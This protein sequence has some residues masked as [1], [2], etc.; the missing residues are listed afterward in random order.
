MLSTSFLSLA[1]VAPLVLAFDRHLAHDAL[2]QRRHLA[3][4]KRQYGAAYGAPAAPAVPAVSDMASSWSSAS[5]AASSGMMGGDSAMAHD[6][7]M[8]TGHAGASSYDTANWA[9]SE[10][11]SAS[12]AWGGGGGIA[13]DQCVQQCMV[14]SSM[15][16]PAAS[17]TDSMASAPPAAS[18]SA[19]AGGDAPPPPAGY[20]TG[21]VAGP[22]QVVVAPKKGDLR[23]VPFNIAVKP[24]ETVEFVWGAGPHTVTQSSAASIC[25]ASQAD[26]AF[27]SGMQNATFTFPVKVKD[28]KPVFYYCAV[29]MHCK[30]GMFGLINGQVSLDGNSSFGSYMKTWAA[31]NKENQQ[32]WDETVKITIDFPDFASWGDNLSTTQFED[33]ALPMAMESTLMTRQYF[34][35]NALAASTNGSS[36]SPSSPSSPTSAPGGTAA[37]TDPS[38]SSDA[39]VS[40]ARALGA[41]VSTVAVIVGALGVGVFLEVV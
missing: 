17:A 41:A 4:A 25:N 12:A 37:A 23:M 9:P 28:D 22:G 15:A 5:A 1:L 18:A 2:A 8:A 26:G 3:P 19:A 32:M 10:T 35:L 40:S 34:A 24:G 31:K 39:Q 6:S 38:A 16:W 30:M 11:A 27:K 7:A 13:M 33:W 29:A 20:D 36:S 14:A 21:L